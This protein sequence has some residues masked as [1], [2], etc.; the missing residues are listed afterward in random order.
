MLRKSIRHLKENNMGYWEHFKFA[1][2]HGTLCIKAG[3]LLILHSIM[4][5]FFANTG[6]N[7][8]NKLN[9]V[10]T[11]QNE[12]LKLKNRVEIFKK[13]VYHYRSKELK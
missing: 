3:L 7:L 11:E 8:V 13:I 12:Y 4:P 10:F 9:K 6:S 5:A 1:S 2:K